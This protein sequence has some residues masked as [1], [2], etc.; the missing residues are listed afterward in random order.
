M[1]EVIMFMSTLSDIWNGLG[2]ILRNTRLD[3]E[4]ST[5]PKPNVK[6]NIIIYI[7]SIKFNYFTF[8]K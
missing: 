8:T 2:V 7:F 5:S 1:I 6:G 3:K 4:T